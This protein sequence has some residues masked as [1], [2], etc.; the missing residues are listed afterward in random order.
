[1]VGGDAECILVWYDA[2]VGPRSAVAFVAPV[3][4]FS[5]LL[6][7]VEPIASGVEADVATDGSRA[8]DEYA[9]D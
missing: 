9:G 7:L 5:P 2:A 6:G 4:R 1:M 8:A 3:N